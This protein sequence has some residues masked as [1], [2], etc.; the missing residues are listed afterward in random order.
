MNTLER[1]QQLSSFLPYGLQGVVTEERIEMLFSVTVPHDQNPMWV[2][3]LHVDPKDPTKGKGLT[4]VFP[5]GFQPIVRSWDQLRK[6]ISYN[7]SLIV[8]ARELVKDLIGKQLLSGNVHI[9]HEFSYRFETQPKIGQV[10]RLS[11]KN[12]HYIIYCDKP[13]LNPQF[14]FEHL[15][16]WNFDVYGWLKSK[17]RIAYSFDEIEN[18]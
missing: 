4:D 5:E 3:T 10:L 13:H 17:E 7:E 11:R 8:P 18:A 16:K 6:S 1:F 9:A 12:H 2:Q 15:M 14:I